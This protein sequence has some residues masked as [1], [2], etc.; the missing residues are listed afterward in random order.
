MY[1]LLPLVEYIP[2]YGIINLLDPNFESK[3][4]NNFDFQGVFGWGVFC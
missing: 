1:T 3:G 4:K 2:E